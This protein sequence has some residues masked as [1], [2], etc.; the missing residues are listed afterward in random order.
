MNFEIIGYIILCVAII[1]MIGY[2]LF[3]FDHKLDNITVS[4]HKGSRF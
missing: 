3:P 2:V 4:N 1:A